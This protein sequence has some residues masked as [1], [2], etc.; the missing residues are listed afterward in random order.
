LRHGLGLGRW[1][2]TPRIAR[3]EALGRMLYCGGVN[4]KRAHGALR[5]S[6]GRFGEACARPAQGRAVGKR[7]GLREK[8]TD[9]LT[10]TYAD[11]SV[12]VTAVFGLEVGLRVLQQATLSHA[13]PRVLSDGGPRRPGDALTKP[14]KG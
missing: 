9:H 5:T 3:A 6:E 14:D 2:Q 4:R 10:T 8:R 1:R 13:V 11:L 12:N 7:A